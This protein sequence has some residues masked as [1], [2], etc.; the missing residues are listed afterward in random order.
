MRPSQVA[1]F[2]VN[3]WEIAAGILPGAAVGGLVIHLVLAVV[4]VLE[5]RRA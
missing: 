3:G 5:L 2:V 4:F 1:E